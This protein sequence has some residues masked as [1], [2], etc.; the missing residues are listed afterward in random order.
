ML[1]SWK[2]LRK[3][4]AMPSPW[5]HLGETPAM[6][7]REPPVALQRE[8]DL[9]LLGVRIEEPVEPDA[10]RAPGVHLALADCLHQQLVVA[11]V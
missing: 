7:P 11:H 4:P 3:I 9:L 10:E 8:T 1:S 6:I 2:H 5:K